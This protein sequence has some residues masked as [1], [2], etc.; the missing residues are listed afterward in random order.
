MYDPK[1]QLVEYSAHKVNSR[2]FESNSSQL[3]SRA[4]TRRIIGHAIMRFFMALVRNKKNGGSINPQSRDGVTSLNP[5]VDLY[6][7][8]DFGV[9]YTL[10][11]CYKSSKI[12]KDERGPFPLADCCVILLHSL[13]VFTMS[14]VI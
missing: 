9:L 11:S 8:C 1:A 2:K 4:Y 3:L 10:K 6:R 5:R 7:G 12:T 14:T 13:C